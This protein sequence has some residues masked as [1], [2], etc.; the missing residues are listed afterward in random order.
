MKIKYQNERE[1]LGK[2]GFLR[3]VNKPS[4]CRNPPTAW[5]TQR[6]FRGKRLNPEILY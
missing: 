4:M 3:K 6:R 2:R 5:T 1:L